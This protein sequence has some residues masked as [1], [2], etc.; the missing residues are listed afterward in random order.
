[1]ASPDPLRRLF[2]LDKSSPQFHD[3]VTDILYGKGYEGWVDRVEGRDV[4]KLVD[5]LDG[6]RRCALPFASSLK[7]P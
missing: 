3:Q 2:S 6:V 1:M 4:V 7:L 5:Y